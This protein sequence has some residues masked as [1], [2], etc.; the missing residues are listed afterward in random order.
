MLVLTGT[1]VQTIRDCALEVTELPFMP[2]ISTHILSTYSKE[3]YKKGTKK[4]KF[5]RIA[6][7][8]RKATPLR[9]NALSAMFNI[10]TVG[11]NC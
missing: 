1:E 9:T 8:E 3:N 11:F 7:Y 2:H 10:Q 5:E 6:H 4:H